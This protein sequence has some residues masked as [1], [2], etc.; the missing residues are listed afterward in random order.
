MSWSDH[1]PAH[2]SAEALADRERYQLYGHDIERPSP[3]IDREKWR[4]SLERAKRQIADWFDVP[5]E[6][7]SIRWIG[8]QEALALTRPKP[9]FET[10]DIE[11]A[12]YHHGDD[13]DFHDRY[14]EDAA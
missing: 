5:M 8:R 13:P 2:D 11:I 14:P 12:S 7:A 3:P 1:S 6:W 4:R 10:D 9:T